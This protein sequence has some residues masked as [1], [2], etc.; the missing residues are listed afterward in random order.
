M[1]PIRGILHS[2]GVLDDATIENQ[3]LERFEKV[4]LPKVNGAWNLHECTMAMN[5]ELDFFVFFSSI[6]SLLGS[7]GQSNY[8]A[9][10]AALDGLAHYRRSLGLA[11]VSIQWGAWTA[12][13]MAAEHDTVA[14]L[15]AQG[16]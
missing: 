10:N 5:I 9:A 1:P 14:R 13:G 15:E 2:A 11:G 3:S 16:I 12:A 7:P 4:F 8:A 6:A